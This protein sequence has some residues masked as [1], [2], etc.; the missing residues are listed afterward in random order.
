LSAQ[1]VQ[2]SQRFLEEETEDGY[3]PCDPS[4][5]VERVQTLEGAYEELV[6]L[7]V[8]RRSR[9]E[10]SRQLWQF[11]WDMAEEENWIKEMEQILS[12]GDI[13]HDLTTIHLLLSKHKSLETEIRA[14]ENTLRQSMAAG[15]DLI[16]QV[17][18]LFISISAE[19][20]SAK[21]NDQ[22]LQTKLSGS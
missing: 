21:Y 14:H 2:H 7:A 3:R 13:G 17:S 9:L 15:E 6:R 10:E 11:Y 20:F 12:Q 19:N 16:S 4:I 8:E 1:V 5:I 22:T 18:I